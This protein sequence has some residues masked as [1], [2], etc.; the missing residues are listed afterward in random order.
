MLLIS[1]SPSAFAR[2]VRIALVEKGV[3]FELRNEVPWNADTETPRYNPLE[4]LPILLP[5]DGDPLYDSTLILEWIE[6]HYPSPPLVPG[7]LVGRF[8]TKRIQVLAEGVMNAVVL[9]F[10]EAQRQPPSR[11]WTARQLRKLVG[12]IGELERRLGSRTLF[13]GDEMTL[14]DIAVVSMLGFLDVAEGQG[15]VAI[16]QAIDPAYEAW[17]ARCPEL[18]RFADTLAER[19]SVR[20]T[21]PVMFEVRQPVV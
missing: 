3:D 21:A 11:D 17:R 16:W 12:G 19:P 6:A 9:L 2:K 8:E 10:W 15:M 13:V 5:D 4:Q 18:A 1:A 14:A 20:D 7:D